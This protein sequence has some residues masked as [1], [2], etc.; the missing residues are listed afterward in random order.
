M[1]CVGLDNAKNAINVG[2][3]LRA[4]HA[5]GAAMLAVSGT[6]D[7]RSPT[8]VSSAYKEIP[9]VRCGDLHSVIPFG[10][11]PVAVELVPHAEN[12]VTFVHPKNAIYIFGAEDNTL[13]SRVLAYC[14]HVVYVPTSI[15]MNLSACVNVVLY[16]RIAKETVRNA[17]LNRKG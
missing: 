1:F 3:A 14:K 9:L 16:D 12:L 7:V 8:D 5:Y 15:C 6:R 4:C 11:V 2:H 10:C 13:G 17:Q